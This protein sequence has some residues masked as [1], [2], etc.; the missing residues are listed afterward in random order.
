MIDLCD[1]SAL[2]LVVTQKRSIMMIILIIIQMGVLKIPNTAMKNFNTVLK[3]LAYRFEEY[4]QN[5]SKVYPDSSKL[6][7]YSSKVYSI[8][9]ICISFFGWVLKKMFSSNVYATLL[10]NIIH[11]W[12]ICS[13]ESIMIQV[14]GIFF[15]FSFPD[16]SIL[17]CSF[18]EANTVELMNSVKIFLKTVA[19]TF[20]ELIV[21]KTHPKNFKIIF[22]SKKRDSSNLYPTHFWGIRVFAAV[23]F[24]FLKAVWTKKIKFHFLGGFWIKHFPQMCMLQTWGIWHT[25][26][27]SVLRILRRQNCWFFW[28][29]Q[30]YCDKI[31]QN[32]MRVLK[33]L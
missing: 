11:I 30:G 19:Y 7:N 12:G 22:L 13:E 17:Y 25:F 2:C 4:N 14:W 8:H 28:R 21:F 31:P 9:Q 3:N 18:D 24:E 32:C 26:E 15:K 29:R 10:K 16:S 27:E 5:S 33:N 23:F 6:C 20:E 1:K